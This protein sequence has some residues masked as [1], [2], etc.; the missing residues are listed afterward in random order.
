M[1]CGKACHREAG[2]VATGLVPRVAVTARVQIRAKL[3]D[4][5]RKANAGKDVTTTSVPSLLQ[6]A[7]IAFAIPT[8]QTY[9][10]LNIAC[11]IYRVGGTEKR[12]R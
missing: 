10:S 5:E 3:G 1:G 9:I 8:C 12:S 6:L 11:E 7:A 2:K 4:A